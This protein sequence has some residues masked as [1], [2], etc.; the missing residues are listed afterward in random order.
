MNSFV[1]ACAPRELKGFWSSREGGGS[2]A[3]VDTP[4]F[5]IEDAVSIIPNA[6]VRHL[7]EIW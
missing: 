5:D 6:L 4:S 3:E 2:V 1:V 7:T